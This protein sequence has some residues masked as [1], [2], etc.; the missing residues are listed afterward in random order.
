MLFRSI[1]CDFWGITASRE[2]MPHLQS[3]HLVFRQAALEHPAFIEFF[4]AVP[5]SAERDDA[6][7]LEVRLALWLNYNKVTS[8]VYAPISEAPASCNPSNDLWKELLNRGVPMLKK[9]PIVGK[10]SLMRG[11]KRELRKHQYDTGYIQQYLS[12][13]KAYK[14]MPHKRT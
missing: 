8:G 7:A 1:P 9:A 2:R 12:R 5:L 11:W 14:K 4:R 13:L 6:I 10:S 3:F